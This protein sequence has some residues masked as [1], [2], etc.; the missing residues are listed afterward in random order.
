MMPPPR[1]WLMPYVATTPKMK[2][3][4]SSLSS[5]RNHATGDGGGLPWPWPPR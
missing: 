4:C 3:Q 5:I 1:P 2:L